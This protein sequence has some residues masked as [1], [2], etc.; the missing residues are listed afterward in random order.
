VIK[1]LQ[2]VF[3]CHDPDALM[4]FW[5]RAL[6]YN[7]QFCAMAPEELTQWRKGF[8][9]FDGR[10]R[11]DD[12]DGRRMPVYTQKVPEPKSGRNRLRLEVAVPDRAA[13]D[14]KVAALGGAKTDGGYT[15]VEGNEFVVVEDR[16]A[17]R[18]RSIV[19]DALD[20]QAQLAFWS[21]ATGYVVS[22][23]RCDPPPGARYVL[24]F[25]DG[26]PRELDLIPGLRFVATNER[27]AVKN[28]LHLDVHVE[29]AQ[30]TRDR[31]V[32]AGAT[33]L[34]WDDEHVLADPEGNEL[35]V[36]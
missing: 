6:E 19:I 9:Q 18:L 14:A 20:P 29:D 13:F 8:P 25:S 4:R 35:C 21:Q 32:A 2:L 7:N 34:R 23:D 3:D 33:V 27:K 16:G 15:D 10:G 1:N 31:L 30:A 28:R 12:A 24:P 22:A 26:Q 36:N 5:G 11:I 17:T